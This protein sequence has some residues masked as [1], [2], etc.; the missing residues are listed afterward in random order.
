MGGAIYERAMLGLMPLLGR[1]GLML[2]F[3]GLG[4]EGARGCI[5]A[6]H[7]TSGILQKG[8]VAGSLLGGLQ[9]GGSLRGLVSR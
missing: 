9:L 3:R 1:L 2:V 5:L 6:Q 8:L 7:A 4:R